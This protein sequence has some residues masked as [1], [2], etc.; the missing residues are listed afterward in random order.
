MSA[1]RLCWDG[2]QDPSA[3][4]QEE[5]DSGSEWSREKQLRE[6]GVGIRD[7]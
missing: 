7:L 3:L 2:K 6:K 5:E 4:G 1:P